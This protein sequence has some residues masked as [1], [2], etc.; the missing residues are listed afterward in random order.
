MT[1]KIFTV[2]AA[3][4]VKVHSCELPRVRVDNFLVEGA[5]LAEAFEA[6]SQYEGIVDATEV[7]GTECTQVML[8]PTTVMRREES[9]AQWEHWGR[10]A[11]AGELD[12]QWTLLAEGSESFSERQERLVAWLVAER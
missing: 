9:L 11:R 2:I 3:H 7:F 6:I 5:S 10:M 8:S 12:A 4:P 1:R